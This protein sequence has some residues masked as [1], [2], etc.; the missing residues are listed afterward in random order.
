MIMDK[1][2]SQLPAIENS[3]YQSYFIEKVVYVPGL[4]G[5]STFPKKMPPLF[6]QKYNCILY[7]ML[8]YAILQGKPYIILLLLIVKCLKNLNSYCKGNIS[9]IKRLVQNEIEKEGQTFHDIWRL[10][11]T[12]VIKA[13][14]ER[15]LQIRKGRKISRKV[16]MI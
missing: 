13:Q 4:H 11:K 9:N 6:P 14:I 15:I 7:C 1:I 3:A 12:A 16:N 2:S 8:L 10:F 5:K